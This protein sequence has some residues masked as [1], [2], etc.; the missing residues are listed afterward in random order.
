VYFELVFYS[1]YK[2][3]QEYVPLSLNYFDVFYSY[4]KQSQEYVPLSLNYFDVLGRISFN[5]LV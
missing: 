5:V 1:Y 2:Q 3:S 4:Y